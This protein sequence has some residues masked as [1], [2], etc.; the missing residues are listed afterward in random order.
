MNVLALF[1]EPTDAFL[2]SMR[3]EVE[4]LDDTVFIQSASVDTFSFLLWFI[5]WQRRASFTEYIIY[6]FFP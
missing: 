5:Q 1:F 6:F 3:L 2:L 4:L